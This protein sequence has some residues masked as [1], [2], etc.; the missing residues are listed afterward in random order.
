MSLITIPSCEDSQSS[1]ESNVQF[2]SFC[3][4]LRTASLNE[5]TADRSK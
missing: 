4:N 3:V 1:F 2:F 5:D